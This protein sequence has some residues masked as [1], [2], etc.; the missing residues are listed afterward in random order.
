MRV[1]VIGAAGR[2]GRLVVEQALGHG[3][4]VRAFVHDAPLALEHPR[5]ETVIGDAHDFDTMSE[6]VE[7]MTA[8]AVTVGG[9]SRGGRPVNEGTIASVI[10][11]MALH[12][13]HRLAALSAAGTFAR[14]DP[15]LGLS[16]RALM[17]TVLKSTYDDLE[18]MERRIMAS[19]LD[20]TIVRPVGLSDGPGTGDY[21]VSRDGTI[22]RKVSTI[23]RA[24]VAAVMLKSLETDLYRRRAIVVAQ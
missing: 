22:P 15:N 20:W 4:E 7:G 19:D 18:A 6:A 24:D 2:T 16:F 5:L 23:S 13:V 11:A 17:A 10:Y 9:T 12:E 14:K 21:R 8:V 3:H 1:L